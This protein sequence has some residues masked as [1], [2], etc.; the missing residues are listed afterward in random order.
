M[1]YN[2][3]RTYSNISSHA[4]VQ[5]RDDDTAQGSASGSFISYILNPT[6]WAGRV[7]RDSVIQ[8]PHVADEGGG[9]WR[10]L[11]VYRESS[12]FND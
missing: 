1:C 10:G 8:H 2:I 11:V 7:F 12:I 9:A 3:I 4:S 6:F 5:F